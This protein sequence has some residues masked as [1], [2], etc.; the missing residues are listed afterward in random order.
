[1]LGCNEKEVAKPTP[2]RLRLGVDSKLVDA[3]ENVWKRYNN[4]KL[5]SKLHHAY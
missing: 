4:A 3:D 2:S 1:M 5:Q